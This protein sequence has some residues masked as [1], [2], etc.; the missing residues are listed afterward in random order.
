MTG[1]FELFTITYTLT[2]D[3]VF[4]ISGLQTNNCEA[5]QP[6]VGKDSTEITSF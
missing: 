2:N 4:A 5:F 6:S 3:G 1:E